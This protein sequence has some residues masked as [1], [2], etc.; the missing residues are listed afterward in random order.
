MT[1]IQKLMLTEE[2][3]K[4]LKKAARLIWDIGDVDSENNIA[5]NI[6]GFCNTVTTLEELGDLVASV[7]DC[8]E[9]EY[10]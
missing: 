9:N 3:K 4:L 8:A 10:E 6:L 5:E 1:T 2:E 7:A